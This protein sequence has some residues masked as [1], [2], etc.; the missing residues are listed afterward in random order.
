MRFLTREWHEQEMEPDERERVRLAFCHHVGAVAPRLPAGIAAL[1]EA[2]GAHSLHDGRVVAASFAAEHLT[3]TVR[4]YDWTTDL[5]VAP[6]EFVLRYDRAEPVQGTRA[7][8]L[9][10]LGDAASE[11]LYCELDVV[12]E[13][14]FEHRMLLW[15]PR[16]GEIAIGFADASVEL[17]SPGARG[18]DWDQ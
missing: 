17:G 7:A 12:G 3:V 1:V 6:R 11:I 10:T 4:G 5:P 8:L 15:P 16:L 18:D 13:G 2:G 9:T 14:R